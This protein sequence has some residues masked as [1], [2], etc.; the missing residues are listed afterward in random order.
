M[1][2]SGRTSYERIGNQAARGELARHL[3]SGATYTSGGY[4][5]SLQ[6]TIDRGA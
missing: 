2:L 5:Q 4:I 3:R 1:G 6:S